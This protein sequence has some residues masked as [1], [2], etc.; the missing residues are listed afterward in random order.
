MAPLYNSSNVFIA[1]TNQRFTS[2]VPFLT[3]LI[4]A[5][6]FILS[7]PSNKE[8][9]PIK[10][11]TPIISEMISIGMPTIFTNS[12]ETINIFILYILYHILASKAIDRILKL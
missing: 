3:F 10:L 8:F 9:K 12:I 1:D 2:I 4:N 11:R 7:P 5:L 6:T